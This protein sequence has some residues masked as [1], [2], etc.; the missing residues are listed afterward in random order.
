MRVREI[1]EADIESCAQLY[2]QVFSD[3]PWNENWSYL[4][5]LERLLHFYHSK[6][7]VG[8]LAEDQ[9]VVSFALGNTEPYCSG[10]FFYLREMCTKKD[11]QGKGVGKKVLRCLESNL[12][13]ID[14][15]H[16]YLITKRDIPAANFYLGCGFAESEEV[17]F[18]SK[19]V[20]I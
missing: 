15:Q 20:G 13:L 7:F 10:A 3:E 6:G 19:S 14:V 5:A 4:T 11:V 9:G 18:Y 2:M 17:A 1:Q 8:A 12:Q 16:I